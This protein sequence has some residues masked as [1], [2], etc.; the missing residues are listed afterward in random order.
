MEPITLLFTLD[1]NY[2]PQLQVV[3]TSVRLN[4]PGE[5][6]RVFL[7]HRGLTQSEV[8]QIARRCDAYGWRFAP[9]RVDE[10][11]F[12]DAPTTAQYPQEMGS[13][14]ASRP[15]MTILP[16]PF[17]DRGITHRILMMRSQ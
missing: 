7:M 9:V 4:N 10:A 1:A 16:A 15:A 12:A 13:A 6:F 3:L 8:L 11:L 14:G 2:L 17:R 5:T